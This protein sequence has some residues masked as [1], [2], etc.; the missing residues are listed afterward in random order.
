M[1]GPGATVAATTVIEN[2]G[3]EAL[4]LPSVTVMTI[5]E[6]VPTALLCGVPVKAPVELS[7]LAQ[8]GR[9]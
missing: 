9:F 4:E 5:P 3:R 8:L 2:A 6:D 1:V 7:K